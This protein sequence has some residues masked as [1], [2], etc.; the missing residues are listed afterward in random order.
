MLKG[1]P[2]RQQGIVNARIGVDDNPLHLV[3]TELP[4]E[5][6]LALSPGPETQD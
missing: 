4:W 5:T 6:S 3:L 2:E 1:L